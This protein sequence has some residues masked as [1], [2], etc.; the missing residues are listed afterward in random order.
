MNKLL[1]AEFVTYS[2]ANWMLSSLER[3]GE[4]VCSIWNIIMYCNRLDYGGPSREYFFLLS[5]ELFN[6]YY[7]LFEYSAA[8]TYTAQV[9][10]TSSF[11][12]NNLEWWVHAPI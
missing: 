4:L 3:K 8:N 11:I 7:G 12:E 9:S 6:P 10:A 1:A 2:D 5:H